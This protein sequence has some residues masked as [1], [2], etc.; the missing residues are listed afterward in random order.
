MARLLIRNADILTLDAA[1]EILFNSLVAIDGRQIVGVGRVPDGFVP[2][3]TI[4]GANHVVLPGLFNAHAHVPMTLQ[5]GW[6]EDLD[7][8]R[9]FNER[10]WVAESALTE[11]DVYWGA[12]LAA[13]EMIRG[14]TVAFA[15]HYFWEP[16]VARVVDE[17][18]LKALLG[19]CVFG[20][21][22]APEIGPTTLELTAEFV[23]DF[24]NSAEGRIKTLLAPHSPYISSQPFLERVARAAHELSV[25]CHIHA[26]ETREQYENSLKE[27]GRTPVRYLADLGIFDNP[28][29][30]AHAIYLDG[31]D[32]DILREKKMTV[33]QCPKTHMK[34]AMG[35]TP[36]PALLTAGVNVA[37]GTDG[38]PSN[39][40][41]DMLGATR[42]AALLQKYACRDATVLPS[43]QALKLATANGARAMGFSNSGAIREGADADLILIDMDKPHLLPRHDLAANA[44]H[45]AR[46]GDV[47]HVIV[48]GRILMHKGELIT[49]DEEKIKREAEARAFRLVNSEH[50]QTQTYRG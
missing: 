14:G 38:P 28:G 20:S 36:V 35:T 11:E 7:I 29:I 41:L 23:K 50:T 27:H 18:G 25:G 8:V 17:A 45:S 48:D 47:D 39:N 40:D 22:A 33:V 1:N 10:I 21:E 24:Q 34:L 13:C 4:D 26:A 2:D 46:P 43:T 31:P 5:R 37:L 42:L 3:A 15:D 6:A 30:V 12:A 19:W 44:V 32:V 16:Q 9:W 49:L